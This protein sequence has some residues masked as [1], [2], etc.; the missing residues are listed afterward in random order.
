MEVFSRIFTGSGGCEISVVNLRLIVGVRMLF[1]ILAVFKGISAIVAD[2]IV[3]CISMGEGSAVREGRCTGCS[4]NTGV[5]VFSRAFAVC[6][7]GK[8]CR[9]YNLLIVG[10]VYGVTACK[11]F[12]SF[13]SAGAGV[14]VSSRVL[15]G[16]GSF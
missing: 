11:G 1:Y 13:F 2:G 7:S 4:A 5:I 9:G 15:T 8:I 6:C 10:V 16:C 12:G 14:V 3:V